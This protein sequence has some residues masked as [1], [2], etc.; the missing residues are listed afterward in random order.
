MD[1]FFAEWLE[2][3]ELGKRDEICSEGFGI[4]LYVDAIWMSFLARACQRYWSVAGK[5]FK[6]FLGLI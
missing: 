3:W 2:W 1:G 5:S 4:E 6:K